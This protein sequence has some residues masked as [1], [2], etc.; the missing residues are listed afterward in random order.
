MSNLEKVLEEKGIK[1]G[2][3]FVINYKGSDY[4]VLLEN[5]KLKFY[6]YYFI[7]KI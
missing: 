5:G 7:R 1:A 6:D 3:P 4:K 2:V